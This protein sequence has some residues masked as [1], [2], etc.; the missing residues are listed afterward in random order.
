MPSTSRRGYRERYRYHHGCERPKAALARYDRVIQSEA[1]ERARIAADLEEA[2]RK[3]EKALAQLEARTREAEMSKARLEFMLNE[4]GHYV[5]ERLPQMLKRYPMPAE[6]IA[7]VPVKR[8]RGRPRKD[9][10]PAQPRSEAERTASRARR[11]SRNWAGDKRA[12]SAASRQRVPASVAPAVKAQVTGVSELVDTG[13]TVEVDASTQTAIALVPENE[14]LGPE[15]EAR[16]AEVLQP[17]SVE[18]VVQPPLAAPLI[19]PALTREV[20]DLLGD[21]DRPDEDERGQIEAGTIS[22]KVLD[23]FSAEALAERAKLR[24]PRRLPAGYD[25]SWADAWVRDPLAPLPEMVREFITFGTAVDKRPEDLT[26]EE[27]R[28]LAGPAMFPIPEDFDPADY[29]GRPLP[30][31]FT[32]EKDVSA[33]EWKAEIT[34]AG[35]TMQK[36]VARNA[37]YIDEVREIERARRRMW[38]YAVARRDLIKGLMEGL[39]VGELS[40]EPVSMAPADLA[41]SVRWLVFRWA[42]HDWLQLIANA[43]LDLYYTRILDKLPWP[44]GLSRRVLL[45]RFGKG[46]DLTSP[47]NMSS[48]DRPPLFLFEEVEWVYGTGF[49]IRAADGG[50]IDLPRAGI[51]PGPDFGTID[52]RVPIERDPDVDPQAW[53]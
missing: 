13:D 51:E 18:P 11:F 29:R 43:D 14:I 36:L 24:D 49:G 4:K 44:E 19:L 32:R 8:G 34:R 5:G 17:H 37:L 9:G 10:S 40:F 30:P 16:G 15:P 22:D 2:Q 48:Q 28:L 41:R 6:E 25:P 1:D 27:A 35:G 21:V 50:R 20:G 46:V 33:Y 39:A 3:A 38:P 26:D 52:C 42:D 53:R 31:F 47:L 45:E 7:V 12:R 23:I